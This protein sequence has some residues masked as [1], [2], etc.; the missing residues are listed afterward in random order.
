MSSTNQTAVELLEPLLEK[1]PSLVLT[2]EQTAGRGRKGNSWWS[3]GGALTFSVVMN[4]ASLGLPED[5]RPLMS[6]V[7]GVA[8][9]SALAQFCGNQTVLMKW[10]NDVYV[11]NRKICGILAEQHLVG[12]R[13]GSEDS[14]RDNADIQKTG[15]ILGIGVNVNNS[16][17]GAPAEVRQRAV[18]LFDLEH[19]VFDLN[20]ILVTILIKLQELIEQASSQPRRFLADANFHH[21]LNGKSVLVQTGDSL[22]AGKCVGIDDTGN[23]VLQSETEIHRICS[24]I[25]Q[26][27]S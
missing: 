14:R 11:G 15:L 22:I 10:P 3:S 26:R 5:R 8:V 16:L 23:L 21:L 4:A 24:G 17:Q 9:R 13:F 18:S 12:S 19:Q 6:I 27:W 7:T 20:Q 2:A 25:V 1:S